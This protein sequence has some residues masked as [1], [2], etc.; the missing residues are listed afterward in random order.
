MHAHQLFEVPESADGDRLD[1]YLAG[2]AG[3]S[4][5]AVRRAIEAG[6]VAVD[7]V[8][9]RVQ[10]TVVRAG[11]QIT[12]HEV[13]AAPTAPV[14]ALNV[15]FEDDDLLVVDKPAGL[16]TVPPPEGGPNLLELVRRHLG[17]AGRDRLGEV[18]RLD[19]D[20]SGLLVFGKHRDAVAA[21]GK[22]LQRRQ[23][24]RGYLAWIHTFVAPQPERIDAPLRVG[25]HGGAEV[26]PTGT[27]AATRVLPLAWNP[28]GHLALVAASLESGRLHQIRAHLAW[29][30]GPIVGDQRYGAPATGTLGRVA[31]H[32]GRLALRHPRHG[33][34]LA[35][36][37]PPTDPALQPLVAQTG[38]P[39]FAPALRELGRGPFEPERALAACLEQAVRA[40]ELVDP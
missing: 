17:L 21:L 1:R 2:A 30:V 9:E 32:A 19:R 27:P 28:Q 33:Q 6:A 3:W 38:L 26:H 8:R 15:V 13:A 24:N 35:F 36:V 14:D 4:R 25:R 18:H 23:I 7:G 34:G 11:Q 40:Q 31:L 5:G 12:L 22:A 29:A 37:A 39:H 10:A 16:P 20:A